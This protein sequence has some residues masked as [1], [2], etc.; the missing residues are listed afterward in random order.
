M[1]VASAMITEGV[2]ESTLTAGIATSAYPTLEFSQPYFY[3]NS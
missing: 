1:E 3:Y 2:T